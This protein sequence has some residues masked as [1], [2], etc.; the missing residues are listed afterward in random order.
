MA[1]KL[2]ADV[3]EIVDMKN[4]NGIIGWLM[5]GKDASQGATTEIKTEKNPAEYDLV[6]LGTPVW[7]LN[8]TPAI[9][10]YIFKFKD[11]MKKTA[12]LVTSGS[13]PKEKP[14]EFME[15]LLGKKVVAAEGWTTSSFRDEKVFDSKIKNFVEQIGIIGKC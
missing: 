15:K 1:E 12:I 6:I 7:A 13:T 11:Q 9:R 5:G 10:T 2:G 8:S 4:R 14:V 3:D